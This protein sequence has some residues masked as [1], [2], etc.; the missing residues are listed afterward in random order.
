MTTAQRTTA[1]GSST[2][3]RPVTFVTCAQA[4]PNIGRVVLTI[5]GLA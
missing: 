1:F 3:A 2:P 5:R 4:A